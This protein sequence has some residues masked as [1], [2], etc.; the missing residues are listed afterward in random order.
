MCKLSVLINIFISAELD[1]V[2][3]GLSKCNGDDA[4]VLLSGAEELYQLHR[5]QTPTD[6]LSYCTPEE[7]LEW[8]RPLASSCLSKK[9]HHV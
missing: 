9:N 4:N 5:G 2:E 7:P 1:S 6:T 8:T 3:V